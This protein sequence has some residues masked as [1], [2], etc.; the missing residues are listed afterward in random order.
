MNTPK[1]YMSEK[2]SKLDQESAPPVLCM[3]LLV[4]LD[5]CVVIDMAYVMAGTIFSLRK[6]G[7]LMSSILS[8]TTSSLTWSRPWSF[9]MVGGWS[10]RAISLAER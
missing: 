4:P 1:H 10:W 6:R 5:K 2:I 8:R 7:L 9:S 3:I